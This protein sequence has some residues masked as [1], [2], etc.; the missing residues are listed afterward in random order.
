MNGRIVTSR[1]I[2][3]P[4]AA[5]SKRS[6][7][8]RDRGFRQV[9]RGHCDAPRLEKSKTAK[10]I[11]LYAVQM[12]RHEETNS[13]SVIWKTRRTAHFDKFPAA[14]ISAYKSMLKNE[15]FERKIFFKTKKTE[16][17]GEDFDFHKNSWFTGWAQT[18]WVTHFEWA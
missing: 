14:W 18:P 13:L 5:H 16:R 11:I 4:E 9:R 7:L 12:E 1:D 6:P 10:K 17:K 2:S 3:Y 8:R 15:K